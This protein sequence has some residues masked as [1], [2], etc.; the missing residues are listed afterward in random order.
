M[1]ISRCLLSEETEEDTY[2]EEERM[3]KTASG[4]PVAQAHR[5]ELR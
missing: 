1:D 2:L 5:P 3:A 4:G